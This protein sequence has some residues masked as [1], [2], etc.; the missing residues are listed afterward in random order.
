MRQFAT[1]LAVVVVLLA[2][3]LTAQAAEYDVY[4]DGSGDFAT[5]QDAIDGVDNG[6]TVIVHPGTYYENINFG[7]K[8]IILRSE[9]PE[10]PTIVDTTIIDGSAAD[11]VVIF[12]GAEDN[13][14]LLSGFTI[15]N[16]DAALGGG[17]YC[18][19]AADPESLP[20]ISYCVIT[21]NS[22]TTGGGLYRFGG[23]LV[24][25]VI[26]NNSV[27]NTGGGLHS[28]S[29]AVSYC[30]IDGNSASSDGGG[31]FSCYATLDN[32]NI[33]NN[34]SD[35]DGGGLSWFYGDITSCDISGNE[36]A[37]Y[38][39]G[40]HKSNGDISHSTISANSAASQGRLRHKSVDGCL[41]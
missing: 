27:T 36:A 41:H 34:S 40:L 33:I 6:D 20:T 21:A 35:N 22:A 12:S 25:C 38:G 31:V 29:G 17:I 8:S 7:G 11:S 15:T 39:G 19:S 10:N 13:T 30:D 16:G 26:S 18:G 32:C 3:V 28:S 9:D 23:T 4:E 2:S 1:V 14:C 5:I 37:R 24:N